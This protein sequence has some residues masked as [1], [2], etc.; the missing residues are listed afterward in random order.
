VC[1]ERRVQGEGGLVVGRG[2]V[3]D[4][5]AGLGHVHILIASMTARSGQPRRMAGPG[6]GQPR[7]RPRPLRSQRQCRQIAGDRLLTPYQLGSLAQFEAQA[8]S[9]AQ[10]LNLAARARRALCENSPA[11][12]DAWLSS[13]EAPG[14]ASAGAVEALPGSQEASPPWP[15]VVLL[16]HRQGRRP[17]RHLRC[18]ARPVRLV[19]GGD[20]DALTTGHAKKRALLDI[21]AGPLAAGRVEGAFAVATRALATGLH[22]RSGRIVERVRA[23]RRSLA[24][25]SPPRVV[26]DFDERLHGV[27]L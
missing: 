1:G 25:S 24:L 8:G 4:G 15:W 6:H 26:R 22:Y 10:A 11:L 14:H 2:D 3:D 21:A 16:H 18:L 7:L 23:V 20:V 9:G 27:Y 13:V 19:L 12:A 17:P 5:Q